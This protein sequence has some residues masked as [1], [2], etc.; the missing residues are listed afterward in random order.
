[1]FLRYNSNERFEFLSPCFF[2]SIQYL[3]C[4]VDQESKRK[5]QAGPS[6]KPPDLT[7]KRSVS[8]VL[9]A[10]TLCTGAANSKLLCHQ[11][12]LVSHSLTFSQRRT[13]FFWSTIKY[14]LTQMKR[15]QV[16]FFFLCFLSR[17][18]YLSVFSPSGMGR[19]HPGRLSAPSV[20]V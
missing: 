5:Q 19:Y 18:L 16:S 13:L 12:T 20:L 7:T 15:Q 1:M 17:S 11:I 14:S 2:S 3:W 10:K 4:G 6:T 8:S 9:F